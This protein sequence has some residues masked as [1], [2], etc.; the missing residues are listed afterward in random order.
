M[1]SQPDSGRHRRGYIEDVVVDESVRAQ[2]IGRRLVRELLDRLAGVEL[3]A[4][5]CGNEL[6]PF[7]TSLGFVRSSNTR[8]EATRGRDR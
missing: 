8:V 7:Y 3:V 1:G 2:G 4:L 5:D 6:V